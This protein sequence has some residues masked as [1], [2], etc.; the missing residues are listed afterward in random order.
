MRKIVGLTILQPWASLIVAGPKRV[1]NRTWA[2]SESQLRP[3]DYIAIHAGKKVDLAQWF[4]AWGV[5]REGRLEGKLPLLDALDVLPRLA[6][7]RAQKASELAYLES[8]CPYGA[9]VG[10]ARFDGI[11][12]ALRAETWPWYVGPCGWRLTNV[13][14]IE[15]VPCRGA[16]GL[17][18]LPGDVLVAVRALYLAQ[19]TP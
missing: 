3:G 9:I 1:E 2:P 4:G 13:V 17:W 7:K 14:A 10:V 6:D 8:A 5:Q 18:T 11:D 15:P 16:Q 12:R 19:R